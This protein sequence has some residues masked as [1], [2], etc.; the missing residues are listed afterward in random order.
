MKF[1][2]FDRI[3]VYD[4]RLVDGRQVGVV[5]A[6]KDPNG[7]YKEALYVKGVRRNDKYDEI[8][9][10]PKQCRKIRSKK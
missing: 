6:T 9:V 7:L 1:K 10:H 5:A 3:A 4:S 8:I 2:K